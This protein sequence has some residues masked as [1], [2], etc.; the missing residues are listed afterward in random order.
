MRVRIA[1]LADYASISLGDKLNILGIFSNI[2]AT[3]EPI[4]HPQMQLVVQLEFDPGE[5]GN[6]AVRVVLND[7]DGR[8]VLSLGG[9]M[10]VPRAENFQPVT[11][12]QIF[13]FNNATFPKFG[14]YEFQVIV[15]DES[16]AEIPLTVVRGEPPPPAPP[17]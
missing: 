7:D 14:G 11:V 9:E 4:V 2:I 16:R 17:G 5:A 1:A 6:H 10:S 8:E 12:N 13:V 3:A 15:N